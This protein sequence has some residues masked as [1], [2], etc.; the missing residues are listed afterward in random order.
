MLRTRVDDR[1]EKKSLRCL[2]AGSEPVRDGRSSNGGQ[3]IRRRAI[4]DRTG[5]TSSQVPL[6]CV[7]E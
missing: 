2:R 3:M 5:Q 7:V 6:R 1:D 4:G